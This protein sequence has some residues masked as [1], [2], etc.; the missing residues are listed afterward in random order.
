MGISKYKNIVAAT[1]RGGIA[2]SGLRAPLPF[3]NIPE[4]L[5][6]NI[7]T[8]ILSLMHHHRTPLELV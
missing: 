1:G 5:H 6:L 3:W 2:S 4:Y 8:I 7:I